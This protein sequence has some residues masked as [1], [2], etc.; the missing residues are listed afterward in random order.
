MDSYLAKQQCRSRKSYGTKHC[1]LMMLEKCK[2]AAD[3]G[4]CFGSLLTDL[5]KAFDCLSH[6]L[7][8]VKLH[9]YGFDLP[10]LKLFKCTYQ[11]EN[12]GPKSI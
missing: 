2:N 10:A 1:Q 3:E 5:S 12:K 4:N 9:F 6:E 11:I 8:I 7:L